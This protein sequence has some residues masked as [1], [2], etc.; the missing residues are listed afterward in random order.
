MTQINPISVDAAKQ[1]LEL[2]SSDEVE[3]WLRAHISEDVLNHDSYWRP[4]GDQLSNAG[5]IE[6]SPDEINPLVERVVNGMEAVIEHRW[7][8][9]THDSEPSSPRQAIAWLFGIPD[10]KSRNLTPTQ[11]QEHGSYVDLILRGRRERPTVVVHDKGMG[12]HP[13]EFSQTI[14]A[15]NQSRK[16][17]HP[18]L[19][20]MYGQGGSSSFE[21][22]TYTIIVSRRH[23]DHLAGKDDEAGF[24]IVRRQL[25]TRVY[26]YTYLVLP[27]KD[28]EI[29]SFP[30]T[31]AEK[32]GLE[33]GTSVSHV[34]YRDLGQFATQ[35]IT[36]R[37][38]Y[39]LNFRL[40]DPLIPWTLRDE[41]DEFPKASRT[42]R[43]VPYR[44]GE[45]PQTTG[46]GLAQ[47]QGRERTS[48]RHHIDFSYMDE[49]FG[50]I[51]IEWWVL[52][53]ESVSEDG[54]RRANHRQTVEAYRDPQQRYARR[55]IA[56]TRGGQTHAAQT[57]R[58]F[59]SSGFRHVARSV[60]VQVD[61]DDLP[62]HSLASFFASNRADLKTES[63]LAVERALHA[64]IETYSDDLRAVE[65]ERQSELLR[66]GSAEDASAIRDRLDPMIREFYRSR[67]SRGQGNRE[68]RREA[69]EFRGRDIPTFLRFAN[70]D[71]LDLRPGIPTH[72]ELV[73]DASDRAIR[74]RRTKFTVQIEQSAF[75]ARIMGGGS[76]RWRVEVVANSNAAPGA[77]GFITARLESE[78]VFLI[79]SE[80]E[81]RLEVV[82]PPPPYVGNHPPKR[83]R[84]RSRD[85]TVRVRPGSATI[86]VETDARDDL[87][88]SAS[89]SV[90]TPEGVGYRGHGGPRR[91]E[92]R[93]HLDVPDNPSPN[94]IGTV[95][96][97]LSLPGGIEFSHSAP[98][99]I[100]PPL[101]KGGSVKQQQLPEYEI[102]NVL[103]FPNEEA[104]I[105]W[106]DMA[107]ILDTDSGWNGSDVA[108]YSINRDQADDNGGRSIIFYLNADNAQLREAER[109]LVRTSSENTIDA[110]RQQQRTLIC[111][112]LY[113]L[114]VSELE[115]T[116]NTITLP[117]DEEDEPPYLKYRREL[118]RLNDTL[119]YSQREFRQTL[120]SESVLEDD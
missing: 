107:N 71:K 42:M 21:K 66:G 114:A 9:A 68:R 85:G 43:G 82:A 76:G 84:L 26:Q 120:E 38:W 77:T 54:K 91:G 101:G 50:E 115:G 22:A 89:L 56:I 112:H 1:L 69:G 118:I 32:V 58:A 31:I 12:I 7:Q 49:H 6:A 13:S 29:P 53:D 37:A 95:S 17:E 28:R 15:L 20:G 110:I 45:L 78:G 34:E 40:F 2:A 19:L 16:G 113:Q 72:V 104:E 80:Q 47:V 48:V 111:Y 14:V 57:Q 86:T 4:V 18:Y 3:R 70:T 109:R 59:E 33:H 119:L 74:D 88:R 102:V 27:S 67:I 79:D 87:F 11:A 98:L 51:K 92:I 96:A 5:P 62:F 105:S 93:I 8:Q 99:A 116:T 30:G 73:T 103:Q 65:R 25:T 55:R 94:P 24:T 10:G 90:E 46:M 108:A 81:R 97:R 61:T 106:G 63:A 64:A 39:S 75:S 52:Q 44:L 41:R 100:D 36:N 23:P 117:L 60:I 35:Q 83:F